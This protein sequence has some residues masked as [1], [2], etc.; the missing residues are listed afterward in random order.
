[1]DKIR[2]EMKE[3]PVEE[4][5][6]QEQETDSVWYV[7]VLLILILAAMIFVAFFMAR[8]IDLLL[9]DKKRR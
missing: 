8:K 9:K 7:L 2:Q 4:R 5:L 1:M 6:E 3:F